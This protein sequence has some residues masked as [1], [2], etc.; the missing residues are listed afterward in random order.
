[1]C[2]SVC[3]L[4]HYSQD[5]H[6]EHATV[7]LLRGIA[8]ELYF[9]LLFSL[10][11]PTLSSAFV[12]ATSRFWWNPAGLFLW[13]SAG[14]ATMQ[15]KFVLTRTHSSYWYWALRYPSF[16]L[17]VVI[18]EHTHFGLRVDV[19][20]MNFHSLW[21]RPRCSRDG[22]S[23]FKKTNCHGLELSR[24]VLTSEEEILVRTNA[25]ADSCAPCCWCETSSS[26]SPCCTHYTNFSFCSQTSGRFRRS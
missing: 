12:R 19:C 1:M 20:S 11:P 21:C 14:S 3:F 4:H 15:G 2:G 18:F 7:L 16:G 10:L 24:R 13:N 17:H 9:P 25:C 5:H 6:D 26:P 22:T 8:T 23:T